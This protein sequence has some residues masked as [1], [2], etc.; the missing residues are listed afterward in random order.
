MPSFITMEK[1][2]TNEP[3]RSLI[4][5]IDAF[6]KGIERKHIA[7]EITNEMRWKHGKVVKRK[8]TKY[9]AIPAESKIKEFLK[10]NRT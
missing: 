2:L 5:L 3:Y 6:P 10:N 4:H 7:Y 1:A 8:G 9:Y